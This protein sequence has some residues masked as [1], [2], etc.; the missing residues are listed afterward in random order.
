MIKKMI[1]III[2]SAFRDDLY[3]HFYFHQRR[4]KHLKVRGHDASKA[5]FPQEKRGIFSE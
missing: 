5:L 4:R 1:Y 3:L 2:S